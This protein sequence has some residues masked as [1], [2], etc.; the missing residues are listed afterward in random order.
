MADPSPPAMDQ[1]PQMHQCT[2]PSE[3]ASGPRESIICQCQ[4]CSCLVC[5]WPLQCMRPRGVGL[6]TFCAAWPRK[7]AGRPATPLFSVINCVK[8]A[9]ESR[10][11]LEK[12]VARSL[13]SRLISLKRCVASACASS[14]LSPL[15]HRHLV[16]TNTSQLPA[17]HAALYLP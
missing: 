15:R 3:P 9:V 17:L 1:C 5:V 8:A 4:L 7:D 13:S 16:S 6:H 14:L 11:L 10:R 2:Q 12:F